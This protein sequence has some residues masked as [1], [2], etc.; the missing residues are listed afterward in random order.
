MWVQAI[1][2]GI[3]GVGLRASGDRTTGAATALSPA[4][5]Q[6]ENAALRITTAATALPALRFVDMDLLQDRTVPLRARM[7]NAAKI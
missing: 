3:D 1:C 4:V 6:A 5:S 2:V 7:G